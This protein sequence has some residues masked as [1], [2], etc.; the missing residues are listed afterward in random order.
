MSR[1]KAH[2]IRQISIKVASFNPGAVN[3]ILFNALKK[4]RKDINT[5]IICGFDGDKQEARQSGQTF[6]C[7]P[8]NIPEYASGNTDHPFFYAE[9]HEDFE[10]YDDEDY[11]DYES[12]G[13]EDLANRAKNIHYSSSP[14]IAVYDA[15]L[16][17]PINEAA[18]KYIITKREALLAVI[19]IIFED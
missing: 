5:L 16:L 17:S 8:N 10:D 18:Q 15:S 12:Y 9:I 7:K 4:I 14:K 2:K 19:S 13:D 1:K 11:D 3:Q 6:G